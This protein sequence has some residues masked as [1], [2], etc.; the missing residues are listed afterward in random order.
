[1][2]VTAAGNCWFLVEDLSLATLLHPCQRCT[3][4]EVVKALANK[5]LSHYPDP[6]HTDGGTHFDNAVV[7]G[8]AEVWR[9]TLSTAYAKW[10]RFCALTQVDIMY[11]HKRSFKRRIHDGITL[12][13]AEEIP[14]NTLKPFA[15]TVFR[16]AR[17]LVNM[18]TSSA[19]VIKQSRQAKCY[20]SPGNV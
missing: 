8:L 19:W 13:E 10:T 20:Q 9:H 16:C 11:E 3:A 2:P 4:I 15:D 6:V 17:V 5:W 14:S 7:R 18:D 12:L 1:M